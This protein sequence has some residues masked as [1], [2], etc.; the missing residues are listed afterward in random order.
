[1]IDSTSSNN[2]TPQTPF[3]SQT[4]SSILPQRS[5]TNRRERVVLTDSTH[6]GRSLCLQTHHT[7]QKGTP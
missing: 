7:H 6:S 2:I 4:A 5:M 1:M 3:S